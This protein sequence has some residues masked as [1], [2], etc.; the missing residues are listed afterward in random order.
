[1][2]PAPTNVMPGSAG[3]ACRSQRVDLR[4]GRR[5]VGLEEVAEI[6]RQLLEAG[7]RGVERLRAIAVD[8]A[9]PLIAHDRRP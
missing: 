5:D 6:G 3:A 9:K 7:V 2:P 1:M 4:G 8:A